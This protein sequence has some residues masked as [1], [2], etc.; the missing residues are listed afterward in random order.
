MRFLPH[1]PVALPEC[2]FA[3]AGALLVTARKPL[4]GRTIVVTRPRDQA[5]PLCDGIAAAGGIPFLFPLLQIEGVADDPEFLQALSGIDQ[6]ALAIFISPN[7]VAYALPAVLRKRPWPIGLNVAA[8]GQGTAAAL[9]AQ[10]FTRVIVPAEGADSEALL[11]CEALSAAAIHGKTVLLFK[12]IGGRDLLA[13][14]LQAR[15]ARVLAAPCYRRMPPEQDFSALE[16]LH[17]S[18]R[19]DGIVFSSSEAVRYFAALIPE[20]RLGLLSQTPVFC[21]H[22]RIGEA[23]AAIGCKN[24]CLTASGDPGILGALSEYNWP[25]E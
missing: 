2:F 3:S 12:G 13:S 1:W 10:G 20:S 5:T 22:A 4:T 8:V 16:T 21:P 18:G 6:A 23:A 25:S 14:E 17:R 24:I 7:A 9:R 15:G 11:A 19:L